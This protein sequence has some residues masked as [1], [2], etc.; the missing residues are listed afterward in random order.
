MA[1]NVE[2]NGFIIIIKKGSLFDLE[3]ADST[4]N[5]KRKKMKQK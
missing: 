2:N 1:K 4:I 3:L 5:L